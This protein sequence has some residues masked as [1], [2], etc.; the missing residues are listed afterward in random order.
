MTPHFGMAAKA[1]VVFWGGLLAVCVAA[2][3]RLH[4]ALELGRQEVARVASP[5]GEWVASLIEV[6]GGATTA[7]SYEVR[8]T[9]RTPGLRSATLASV[10]APAGP[11][12]SAVR[13]R[14][15]SHDVLR[16]EHGPARSA[17][18]LAPG[19]L[20]PPVQAVLAPAQAGQAG[21]LPRPA[22]Q[23]KTPNR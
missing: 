11:R 9:S 14:W 1:V 4:M 21:Q 16:V 8:G 10:Y 2:A 18:L 6:N 15:V 12:A 5:S 7:F 17:R 13:L 23:T 3:A 22:A 19:W 20:A